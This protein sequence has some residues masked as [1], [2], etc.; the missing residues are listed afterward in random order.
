MSYEWLISLR[1]LKAKRKQAFI[2]LISVI[3]MA[4]IA[5]GVCA[6][7]VILSVMN[8][9]QKDWRDRILG[10][11]AHIMV[12]SHLG[13]LADYEEAAEKVS[14]VKGV[15]ATTPYIYSQAMV[16]HQGRVSGVVLRG[17]EPLSAA[18]ATTLAESLAGREPKVLNRSFMDPRPEYKGQELQAI[19]LGRE[20]ANSLGAGIGSV[21]RLVSPFGRMTPAGRSAQARD[22]LVADL[23]HS[24]MYEYDAGM[25]LLSLEAAQSFLLLGR[26][27]TGIEVRL[28]DI[29]AAKEVGRRIKAEMGRSF[30]TRDWMEL[31]RNLFAAL[32]LEKAAM[33]VILALIV[34]VAAFN[35]ISTLIMTVMEKTKD[36]GILK[37]IGAT[38]SS[39][40]KIFVLQGLIIG[41][42][43]TSFGLGLGLVLCE[44]LRR[45]KFIQLP[46][47]VYYI[48]TMP[49]RVEVLD[50]LIITSASVAI[51]FL[52]TLYPSQQ[53]AKLSPTEVLRYE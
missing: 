43:G 7:I 5:L 24:G 6:L 16:N 40:R 2:S 19:V 11:T 47:D 30:W 21:V 31:N 49:V 50:V 35:I 1:F 15:K 53:G 33:F 27:V 48:T 12:L 20:L 13:P 18:R 46:A 10:V 28:D 42:V 14:R 4:G 52:A 36:I 23:F 37:S 26:S 44:L 29:Y 9:F 39:I 8:G 34:L 32:K 41:V 51:S 25:V 3:T 38:S 17:I 45:Y 22:F